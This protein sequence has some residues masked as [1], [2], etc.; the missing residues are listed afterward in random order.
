[1]SKK[2]VYPLVLWSQ[3]LRG[4]LITVWVTIEKYWTRSG[5]ELGKKRARTFTN[6]DIGTVDFSYMGVLLSR[7]NS[8]VYAERVHEISASF[9]KL[10]KISRTL[11]TRCRWRRPVASGKALVM[12]HWAM[13]SV[14]HYCTAMAIE[15]AATEVHSLV[16]AA[17]FA[18][19]NRS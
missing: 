2:A 7:I 1:M 15:M 3:S 6:F 16:T 14:L 9:T 11:V 10:A 12:L 4:F 17:F 19:R 18:W 5:R 8:K 13:P